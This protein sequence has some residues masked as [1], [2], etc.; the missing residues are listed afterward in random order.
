MFRMVVSAPIDYKGYVVEHLEEISAVDQF[1]KQ[2]FCLGENGFVRSAVQIALRTDNEKLRDEIL[3][4]L[5]ENQQLSDDGLSDIE[6][7][8]NLIP[9]RLQTPAELA[10]FSEQYTNMFYEPGVP[11]SES[12]EEKSDSSEPVSA[13]S[14][15]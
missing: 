1:G 8:Q 15:S 10:L 5:V 3:R 13:G 11:A 6:K 12:V 2:D 4:N 14:E 7:I 9:A